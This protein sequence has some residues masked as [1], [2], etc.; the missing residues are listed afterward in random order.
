MIGVTDQLV[1]L[2]RFVSALD[3]QLPDTDREAATAV[4][5]RAHQ[6]LALPAGYTVVAL[7]GAT[8]SGKSSIFNAI[9]GS[10]I[11]EVDVRRPTT[12]LIHA[13]FWR[14]GDVEPLLDWLAVPPNRRFDRR[15][16][17]D[18]G[19][20]DGLRDLVLLD[21]PDFDSMDEAHHTEVR[22]VLDLVDHV[23]WVLDPQK[24]AD[25]TVHEHYLRPFARHQDTALVALNQVDTLGPSDTRHC[26][27]DLRSLLDTG[28][29]AGVPVIATSAVTPDGLAELRAHLA[30]L[31]AAGNGPK[32]RL[33][34]EISEVYKRLDPLVALDVSADRADRAAVRPVIDAL[35]TAAG[36]PAIVAAVAPA[37]RKRAAAST[38]WPVARLLRRLLP[39]LRRR[40]GQAALPEDRSQ[41]VCEIVAAAALAPEAAL[42]HSVAEGPGATGAAAALAAR[43]LADH[44]TAGLPDPWPAAALAAG[45]ANERAIPQALETAIS[46]VVVHFG[47]PPRWWRT[48]RILHRG[49]A[50]VALVGLVWLMLASLGSVAGLESTG[51][52]PLLPAV[53][54]GCGLGTGLLITAVTG[55]AIRWS[56]KRASDRAELRLRVAVAEVAS[57]LIV[58]PIRGVL[59]TY[60]DARAALRGD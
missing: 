53:V 11:S 43:A 35:A 45:L 52:S 41:P 40:L 48:V 58:S 23:I 33:R 39:D 50:A 17:L 14:A 55:P 21:L 9:A 36:V 5:D 25:K 59:R 12:S 3:T 20:D 31:A 8:G 4:L 60:G 34:H 49:S 51:L 46:R 37:Y 26:L 27:A 24:Y 13:C 10:R 29:L 32:T 56:A 28:G 30:R 18:D 38:Q 6:R 22:R 44:A 7:A 1:T 16:P 54:L 2:R 15:C 47:A 42:D 57:D 19:A